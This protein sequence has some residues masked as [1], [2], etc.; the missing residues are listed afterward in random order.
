LES[1]LARPRFQY[2]ESTAWWDAI[3]AWVLGPLQVAW[4]W[5][6]ETLAGAASGRQGF[7]GLALAALSLA[8][9]VV[10]LIYLGRAIRLAVQTDARLREESSRE[11]RQRSDELWQ[12]AQQLAAAGQWQAASRAAYLSALYALDEHAVLHVHSGLTNHEHAARL[13]RDHPELGD[14]FAE[15]VQRYDRLRYGHYQVTP[16]TFAE[17]SVLVARARS[18][19]S[20]A[21]A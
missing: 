12:Q 17:L 14:S 1:I 15:L 3:V 10:A 20:G 21:S 11:R 5:L 18:I 9:I 2:D 7:V 16:E 4:A 8:V 13:S 19:P 6:W